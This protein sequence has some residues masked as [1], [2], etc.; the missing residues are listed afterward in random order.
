MVSLKDGFTVQYQSQNVWPPTPSRIV[1]FKRSHFI[2]SLNFKFIQNLLYSMVFTRA[3]L[4]TLSR[5]ELAEELI[6]C[7]NNPHRSVR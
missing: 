4:D 1:A 5:E 7:S 2:H 6:K 3:K